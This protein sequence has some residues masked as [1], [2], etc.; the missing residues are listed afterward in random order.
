MGDDPEKYLRRN[1]GRVERDT[2]CE[3][4]AECRRRMIVTA[5]GMPVTSVSMIMPVIMFMMM[6]IMVRLV[7]V[8]IVVVH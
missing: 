7:L 6:I 1:V 5:M 4:P 2:D 8:V 3:R